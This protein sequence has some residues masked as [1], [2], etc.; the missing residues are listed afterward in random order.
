[1][2]K[3]FQA[4]TDTQRAQVD[5]RTKILF[6]QKKVKLSQYYRDTVKYNYYVKGEQRYNGIGYVYAIAPVENTLIFLG[7]DSETPLRICC[8]VAEPMWY[9]KNDV[10]ISMGTYFCISIDGAKKE[11]ADD[12]DVYFF[13]FDMPNDERCGL[14]VFDEN[15]KKIFTSNSKMLKML[16]FYSEQHGKLLDGSTWDYFDKMTEKTYS[17]PEKKIA[18]YCGQSCFGGGGSAQGSCYFSVFNLSKSTLQNKFANDWEFFFDGANRP[19]GGYPFTDFGIRAHKSTRV[20]FTMFAVID[21][22]NL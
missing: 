20:P 15:G 22:T 7:T 11:I 21:V 16:D 3:Y 10:T 13:S 1:M 12:I 5:D 17:Y 18:F 9:N 8:N 14:E 4:V 2:S 6:L 19:H